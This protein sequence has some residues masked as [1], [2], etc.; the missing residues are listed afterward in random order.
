L[1][2]ALL[3]DD[4]KLFSSIASEIIKFSMRTAQPTRY[5]TPYTHVSGF[6]QVHLWVGDTFLKAVDLAVL[7]IASNGRTPAFLMWAREKGMAKTN[8]TKHPC[9]S[10]HVADLLIYADSLPVGS[11]E[12][13]FWL[14]CA[15]AQVVMENNYI[16]MQCK[17]L[18]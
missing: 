1:A 9:P 11:T 13:N 10:V 7:S 8:V 15:E 17:L 4:A 6:S 3:T 12:A 16:A 14:G 18:L 5:I 2:T